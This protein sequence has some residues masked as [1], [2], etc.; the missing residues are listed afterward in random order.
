M[1]IFTVEVD[2]KNGDFLMWN[3]SVE[4][5]SFADAA[6]SVQDEINENCSD[7]MNVR[8][9]RAEIVVFDGSTAE[10]FPIQWRSGKPV[11]RDDI[12]S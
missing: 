5:A 7:H 6:S 3:E 2:D 4:A 9:E 10:R 8:W 11:N 12:V 1:T